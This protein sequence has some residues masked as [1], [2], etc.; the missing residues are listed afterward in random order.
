MK[1]FRK[2]KIGWFFC[3][4][5]LLLRSISDLGKQLLL[6][7]LYRINTVTMGGLCPK[8]QPLPQVDPNLVKEIKEAG[9]ALAVE[10][11]ISYG[12]SAYFICS[13]FFDSQKFF[14]FIRSN[15]RVLLVR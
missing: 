8:I 2:S 13:F 3:A 6:S 10:L 12:V 7:F 1:S 14:G 11:P 4:V 9:A 5:S 15:E